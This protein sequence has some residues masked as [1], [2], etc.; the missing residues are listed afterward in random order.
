MSRYLD[1]VFTVEI[2]FVVSAFRG[3]RL[4]EEEEEEGIGSRTSDEMTI[5]LF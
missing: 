3:I 1:Q 5:N 2:S 4:E